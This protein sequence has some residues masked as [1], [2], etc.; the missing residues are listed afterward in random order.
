MTRISAIHYIIFYR[1]TVADIQRK[2]VKWDRRNVVSRHFQAKKDKKTVA[3]WRLDLENIL[4]V[5]D[6][7]SV[8]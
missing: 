2:L 3:A 4:Q 8:L 5:F 6:V 7:R 1:R